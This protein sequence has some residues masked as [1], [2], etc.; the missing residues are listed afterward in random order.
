MQYSGSR[1]WLDE[2]SNSSRGGL[3]NAEQPLNAST[4]PR[5]SVCAQLTEWK[6]SDPRGMM[7]VSSATVVLEAPTECG[8]SGNGTDLVPSRLTTHIEHWNARQGSDK[9]LLGQWSTF[10]Q[11]SDGL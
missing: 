6:A 4:P 10:V 2:P 3:G 7:P 9:K 11:S 8:A 1:L 5:N